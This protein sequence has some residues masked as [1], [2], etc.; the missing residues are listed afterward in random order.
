MS[1]DGSLTAD[2]GDGSYT[3]RLPWGELEKLQ[4]SCDAGPYFIHGRLM[5]GTWRLCDIRETIRYGLIGGDRSLPN[6]KVLQLIREYVEQRPLLE[7]VILAQAI[8]AAALVGSRDEDL[9]G[10]DEAASPVEENS[11][12]SPTESSDLPQSTEQEQS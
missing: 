10:K 12:H 6:T 8:L 2:F 4:D 3:F 9:S 5:N 7:N 1:R 11:T